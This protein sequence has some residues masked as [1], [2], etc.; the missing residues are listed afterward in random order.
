[1]KV[2]VNA[3][4]K[5]FFSRPSLVKQLV[6]N[7]FFNAASIPRLLLEVFLR[8]DMGERYFSLTWV[9]VLFVILIRVPAGLEY[10]L[11]LKGDYGFVL[12]YV[13]AVAFLGAGIYR[14]WELRRPSHLYD[15]TKFSLST[16]QFWPWLTNLTFGGKPIL[17]RGEQLLFSP[18][19]IQTVIEPALFFLPGLL[20]WWVGQYVGVLV[21]VCAVFYG[22]SY[23][24]AHQLG[25]EFLLDAID[26]RICEEDLGLTMAAGL[27]PDFGRG[28]YF[29]GDLPTDPKQRQQLAPAFLEE[30]KAY[31]IR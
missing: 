25:R 7:F 3:Y 16:G 1:M 28:V 23:V 18:K 5:V 27:A 30:E 17:F 13:F 4:Y 29:P 19:L 8:H 15:F 31:R 14:K 2:V 24:A 9:L 6:L 20:L 12:W 10:A 26:R 11:R 21:M 22:M